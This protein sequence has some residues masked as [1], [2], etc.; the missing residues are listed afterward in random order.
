[1]AIEGVVQPAVIPIEPGLRLRSFDG[2]FDFALRWYQ[3]PEVV[4]LVDGVREPYSPEKLLRMYAYLYKRGELYFIEVEKNGAYVP[5]G[6]VTFWADDMPIVIGDPACRGRGI[7]RKVIG[8]LIERGRQLGYDTL[9]VGEIYDWNEASRKCFMSMG[10]EPC[11]KTE[12]GS[13]YMLCL[14]E[15]DSAS[16]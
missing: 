6:D 12:K 3:D 13:R 14:T 5:V 11:E 16:C 2:K 8:A 10:F 4:Y 1:M 7:G 15:G 9:R